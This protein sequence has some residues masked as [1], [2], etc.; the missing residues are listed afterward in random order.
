MNLERLHYVTPHA[1]EDSDTQI[2][3]TALESDVN[4]T[5]M[6]VGDDTDLLVWL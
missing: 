2:E 4:V 1:N 3:S 5:T 6:L